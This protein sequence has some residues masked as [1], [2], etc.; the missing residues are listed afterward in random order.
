MASLAAERPWL[1]K[2]WINEGSRVAVLKVLYRMLRAQKLS[3]SLSIDEKD[4][5][6]A[7]FQKRFPEA[8]W[9]DFVNGLAELRDATQKAEAL[10]E[11]VHDGVTSR[12][13]AES[14]S[15]GVPPRSLLDF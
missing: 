4:S 7:T 6:F 12:E 15:T 2:Q 5:L 14:P 10:A 9:L 11:R 8:S 13:D 3:P 1:G